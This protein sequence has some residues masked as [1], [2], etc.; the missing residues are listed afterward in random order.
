MQRNVSEAPFYRVPCAAWGAMS[1]V[2]SPDAPDAPCL[3][4]LSSSSGDGRHLC[5]VRVVIDP[6]GNE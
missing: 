6:M 5:A 1:H 4:A 2:A 3:R